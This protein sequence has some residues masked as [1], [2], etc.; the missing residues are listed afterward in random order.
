ME[1]TVS[2]LKKITATSCKST[3]KFS[4]VVANRK[5]KPWSAGFLCMFH[6]LKL[7]GSVAIR[8]A[9]YGQLGYIKQCFPAC[10]L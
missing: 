10:M 1:L 5:E 4:L 8:R 3:C 7:T 6:A 9:E 2:S